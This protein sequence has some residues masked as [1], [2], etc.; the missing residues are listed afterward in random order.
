M[1]DRAMQRLKPD[2]RRDGS[3]GE[4]YSAYKVQS[5]DQRMRLECGVGFRQLRT[6]RRTRP[7]Q[8]CANRDSSHRSKPHP[9]SIPTAARAEN[10]R[11]HG[12]PA[13]LGGNQIDHEVE[14][15]SAARPV[16]SGNQ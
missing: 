5:V 9:Y 14:F 12:E 2:L 3:A 11:W 6:C 1:T 4:R 10:Y 16:G 15:W 8:L 7:G 13:L